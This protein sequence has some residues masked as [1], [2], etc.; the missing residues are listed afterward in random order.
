MQP[1]IID[2]LSNTSGV[3][4]TLSGTIAGL[5]DGGISIYQGVTD[6]IKAIRL[7]GDE[8][9]TPAPAVVQTP[10]E[11]M[12]IAGVSLTPMNLMIG[13]LVVLVGV[14]LVVKLIK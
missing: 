5:F 8:T 14:V 6:R 4:N 11:P 13:G 3:L 12:K 1:T 7:I 9:E 10:S 2:S